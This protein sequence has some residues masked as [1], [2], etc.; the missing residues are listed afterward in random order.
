MLWIKETIYEKIIIGAKS[1]TYVY[2]WTN[3]DCA[4]H[5]DMISH[6]GGDILLGHGVLQK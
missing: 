2:A 1:L 6:T 5:N 4:V 3:E